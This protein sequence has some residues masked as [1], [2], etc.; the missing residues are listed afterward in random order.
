[1]VGDGARFVGDI[2]TE[3][4]LIM[5]GHVTG[6]GSIGGALSIARNAQWHG[7]VHAHDAVI[8]GQ[9]TGAVHCVDKLEL[10]ASAVVRGAV[11]AKRL[12]I[13]RGA[14]IDGDLIVTGDEPIVR[15]EDRRTG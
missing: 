15:F 9:V 7:E 13:A 6:D 12:A 14:I 3:G 8:A 4:S 5:C 2:I 11:S 10:A 1:M